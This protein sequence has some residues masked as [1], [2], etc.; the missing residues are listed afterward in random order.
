MRKTKFVSKSGRYACEGE[1]EDCGHPDCP[2]SGCKIR[3]EHEAA[4]WDCGL[5]GERYKKSEEMSAVIF[6]TFQRPFC[7]GTNRIISGAS[8]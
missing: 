5:C 4:I 7:L 2:A 1:E 3:A 8:K 6:G